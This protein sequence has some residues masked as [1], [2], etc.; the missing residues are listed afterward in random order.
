[1]TK[2][3]YFKAFGKIIFLPKATIIEIKLN[4]TPQK[5][6]NFVL[7]LEIAPQDLIVMIFLIWDVEMG[8]SLKELH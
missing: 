1:M 5:K 6:N 2:I 7:K 8:S 4:L 3:K